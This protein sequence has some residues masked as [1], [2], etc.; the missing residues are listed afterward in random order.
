MIVS[1]GDKKNYPV[2][3]LLI[4][5][6]VSKIFLNM[7]MGH[8]TFKSACNKEKEKKNARLLEIVS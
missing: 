4:P 2:E 5:H 3:L 1:E 6:F 7:Y 8:V